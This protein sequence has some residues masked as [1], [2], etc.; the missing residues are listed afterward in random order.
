M[1][2]PLAVALAASTRQGLGRI[3]AISVALLC[4][5]GVV[6]TLT[7][8][9]MVSLLVLSLIMLALAF[10]RAQFHPLRRPTLLVLV[11][12]LAVVGWLTLQNST[13]R[14]RLT[15]ENDTNWYNAT[16]QAPPRIELGAGEATAVTVIVQNTGETIWTATGENAFALSYRWL[17]ADGNKALQLLSATV[18]LPHDVRPGEHI[19]VTAT[20]HPSLPSGTYLLAW[21]MLQDDILLFRHRDVAEGKSV[22]HILPSEDSRIQPRPLPSGTNDLEPAPELPPTI[23]RRDLWRAALEMWRS[24]PLLGLGPDNF[25][26]LY[27][28]YLGLGRWDNRLSANNLYLELLAT[29]GLLGITSFAA[30]LLIILGPLAHTILTDNENSNSLALLRVGVAGALFAFLLHG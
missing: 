1:T 16:Y 23:A 18:P 11:T 3:L 29:T 17:T 6:L 30:F 21:D 4:T 20:L 12:L 15:T 19:E 7:R 10:A 2:V 26:H 5:T 8:T 14:T 13:F 9:A 25:R 27:G 28:Q 24:R 22:V